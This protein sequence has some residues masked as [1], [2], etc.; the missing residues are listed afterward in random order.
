MKNDM[1]YNFPDNDCNHD[2]YTESKCEW[3]SYS[4]KK[5]NTILECVKCKGLAE[6]NVKVINA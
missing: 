5:Y 2:K 6:T 1:Y 3:E 4:K